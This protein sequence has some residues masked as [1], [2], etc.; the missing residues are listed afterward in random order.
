VD[1]KGTMEV[2]VAYSVVLDDN[3]VQ[4][5]FSFRKA[6]RRPTSEVLEPI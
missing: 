1:A 4:K 3:D 2:V 6:L 5:N